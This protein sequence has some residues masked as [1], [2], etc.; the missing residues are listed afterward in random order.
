MYDSLVGYS[1]AVIATISLISLIGQ[2]KGDGHATCFSNAEDTGIPGLQKWCHALSNDAR[3]RAA[4][5]LLDALKVFAKSIQTYVEGIGDVRDADRHR[6]QEKW[7]SPVNGVVKRDKH[8]VPSGTSTDSKPRYVNEHP[9]TYA[10]TIGITPRLI[11]VKPKIFI[12]P[13]DF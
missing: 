5:S 13:H 2:I 8:S 11:K 1:C 7:E 12:F 9:T 3:E 6:L 4:H 10:K